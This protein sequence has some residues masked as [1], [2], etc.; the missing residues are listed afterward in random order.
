MLQNMNE[1]HPR[2]PKLGLLKC[3]NKPD[4]LAPPPP[5]PKKKKKKKKRDKPE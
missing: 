5:P 2:L 4:T 1:I 3:L